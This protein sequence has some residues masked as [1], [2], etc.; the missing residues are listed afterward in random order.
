MNTTPNLSLIQWTLVGDFFNHAQ[1]SDNWEKLDI[2]DHAPG[3]GVQISEEGLSNASVSTGKLQDGSVTTP[4]YALGSVGTDQLA[5]LSVTTGKLGL[6]SVGNSQLQ[7][8][9]ITGPKIAPGSI[10]PT[11]LAILP[12]VKATNNTIQTIGNRT[13][14]ALT[15]NTT[16]FD[17]D[18]MHS[19]TSN[20]TRLT[21]NTPGAY[22][23]G[24]TFDWVANATGHREAML[25]K[26]G[27]T[28]IANINYMPPA[29]NVSVSRMN[30]AMAAPE[31]C[32]VGDYFE[33]LV[34]Q[35]S[36]GPLDIMASSSGHPQTFGG[37]FVSP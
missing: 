3:R 11:G 8:G 16:A 6:Q 29:D 34:Y 7:D 17:T 33:V 26:N 14:V 32:N 22:V 31:Y 12:R 23:F 19:T 5:D 37:H 25:R 21:V 20:T 13:T 15:W 10:P 36:G 24:V 30:L 28:W 35:A 4:K 18:H 9:S 1:L 2:H 27:T